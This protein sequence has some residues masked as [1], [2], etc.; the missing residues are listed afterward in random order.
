MIPAMLLSAIWLW[1]R[2]PWGY[3]LA[4]ILMVKGATYMLALMTM[5]DKITEEL[6]ALNEGSD[7]HDETS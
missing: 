3:V 2:R 4:S 7:V 6:M 1:Q 5:E